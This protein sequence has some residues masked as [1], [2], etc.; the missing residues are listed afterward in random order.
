M[1]DGK[2]SMYVSPVHGV[3]TLHNIRTGE[4]IWDYRAKPSDLER[5]AIDLILTAEQVR[6]C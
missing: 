1:A 4:Q 3:M 5:V 2:W 6:I